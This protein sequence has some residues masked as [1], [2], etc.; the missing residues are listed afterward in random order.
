LFSP[1]LETPV[2][3]LDIPI[4]GKLYSAQTLPLI[5]D[6]VNITNKLN[7]NFKDTLSDDQDGNSTI[8]ILHITRKVARRINSIHTS[9]LGLHPIVYFY[10][11]KGRHKIA[12]FYATVIFL[13]EL[14]ER[15]KLN[16]FIKVRAAFESILHDFD[17]LVQQIQRHYRSSIGSYPYIKDYFFK[18]IDLLN[19]GVLKDEVINELRNDANFHYLT[20]HTDDI[21]V[22]SKDFT[23]ERKSAVYIRD[24]I[25]SALKCH[26]CNGYIHKNSITIDHID[27]KEDGGVGSIDNG[28]IAHPYCNS[29]IKN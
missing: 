25:K 10:S 20:I 1:K 8:E 4:G 9:S 19:N 2:K 13:M 14:E 29:T 15:K 17:F 18:I 6:F 7:N 24:A 26:I 27:R 3:T 5:L 22:T 11:Q 21:V 28:K 12:S 16:E 23:R